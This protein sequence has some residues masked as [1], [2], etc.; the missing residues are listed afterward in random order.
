MRFLAEYTEQRSMDCTCG[1]IHSIRTREIRIGSGAIRELPDVLKNCEVSGHGLIVYDSNTFQAAGTQLSSV[2]NTAGIPFHDLILPGSHVHAEIRH[3]PRV[4]AARNSNGCGWLIAVGSGSINDMVK[5]TAS[6][7]K[8]PYIVVGTA[9]SMDGFLSANAAIL[10]NGIKKQHVNL[11][12][13]V[14]AVM[15]ADILKTAPAEMTLAGLGDA[16]GKFTSL[17]EWKLNSLCANEPYCPVTAELIR[18]EVLNL[19]EVAERDPLD[20]EPFFNAL[21]RTLLITG[22]AMQ[23]LGNS[24]PASGGEHYISH[25]LDMYGFAVSGDAPSSHGL[26]VALG[27]GALLQDYRQFF[28]PSRNHTFR[29]DRERYKKHITDWQELGVDLSGAIHAKL[30]FLTQVQS[31][32]A[33]IDSGEMRKEAAALLALAP[34]LE[35]VRRKTGLPETPEQIGISGELFDFARNHAVDMRKRLTLADFFVLHPSDRNNPGA[36]S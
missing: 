35:S 19:L 24:T 27:T 15:D 17:T 2:L 13:P 25:A 20:S 33:N 8:L 22:I 32:L 6:Q 7:E 23:M 14:G 28:V 31:N 3:L 16:L 11:T 34:K 1:K 29:I 21:V 30:D 9:P 36:F 4:R 10:E 12:P 5:L 26:Q 18:S